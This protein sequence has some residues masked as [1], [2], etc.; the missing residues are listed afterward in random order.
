VAADTAV[1]PGLLGAQYLLDLHEKY[2]I[3]VVTRAQHDGLEVVDYIETALEDATRQE[4]IEE[5]SRL[6]TGGGSEGRTAV[7]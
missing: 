5:H 7:R 1:G 3:G 4:M 6:G 2:F